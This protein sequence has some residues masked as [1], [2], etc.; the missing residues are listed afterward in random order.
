M[1][2]ITGTYRDKAGN[3]LSGYVLFTPAVTSSNGNTIGTTAPIRVEVVNGTFS[4]N[5]D[6]NDVGNPQAWTYRVEE[7]VPGGR[8]YSIYV[9]TG[10]YDLKDLAP[11]GTDTGVVIPG[12]TWTVN[13]DPASFRG[14]ASAVQG[15]AGQYV[16]TRFNIIKQYG[17][18]TNLTCRV[19]TQTTGGANGIATANLATPPAA[20]TPNAPTT[21]TPTP[22]YGTTAMQHDLVANT[23]GSTTMLQATWTGISASDFPTT[24]AFSS[25]DTPGRVVSL[26]ATLTATAPYVSWSKATVTTVLG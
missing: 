15:A 1:S 20:W 18:L 22:A 23:P 12:F 2:I 17:N 5:L 21:W 11:V 25:T 10:T 14:D 3:N 4:V 7:R 8:V 13:A 16:Y 24:F 6:A 26:T 9:P 19:L